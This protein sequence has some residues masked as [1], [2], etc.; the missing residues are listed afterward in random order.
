L[1][2]TIEVDSDDLAKGYEDIRFR[3][4]TGVNEHYTIVPPD[5]YDCPTVLKSG[6]QG[7]HKLHEFSGYSTPRDARELRKVLPDQIQKI[8][9]LC[10]LAEALKDR[11]QKSRQP[12]TGQD[13]DVMTVRLEWLIG[14]LAESI[15]AT[16]A[17]ADSGWN[18]SA[19]GDLASLRQA[20]E[21]EYFPDYRLTVELTRTSGGAV[22][23]WRYS[24]AADTPDPETDKQEV[25]HEGSM[26]A[27]ACDDSRYPQDSA[28]AYI[29]GH[30]GNGCE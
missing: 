7:A 30:F 21:S 16:C 9:A 29:L 13:G 4:M 18:C 11:S 8:R 25:T 23:S 19:D 28:L 20:T 10:A 3:S 17:G 14:D 1:E 5:R 12:K 22:N 24:L 2:K 15:D 6:V 27:G 26:P